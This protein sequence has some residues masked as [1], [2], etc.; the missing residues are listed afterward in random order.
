MATST[1]GRFRDSKI[2]HPTIFTIAGILILWEIVASFMPPTDFPTLY[3]LGENLHHVF[4]GDRFNFF[5][6]VWV[7]L[8]RIGLGFFISLTVGTFLGICMGIYKRGETYMTTPVM[9]AMTFPAVVWAFISIMVWGLTTYMVP[10]FVIVMGVTPYVAVNIWKGAESVDKD[11][12]EMAEAFN[13]SSYMQ[14]RHIHIPHLK[15][16]LY[17]TGRLAFAVSW[18]ISLIAEVFGTT[19]GIGYV[20]NVYFDTMRADLI[21][22]WAIPVMVLMYGIERLIKRME[23]RSFE[24]RPELGDQQD[25]VLR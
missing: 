22:A 2:F 9:A 1:T 24:W 19:S 13:A 25:E 8:Q 5:E 16:F 15:P 6:H 12:I 11:L 7:S 18:K 20:I 17:S 23:K 4:T 21:I 14:W 10:V 3:Q